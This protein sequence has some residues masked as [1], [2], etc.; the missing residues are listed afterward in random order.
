MRR[1]SFVLA[2]LVAAGCHVDTEGAPCEVPGE[3]T[4][5][6]AGQACGQDLR[7]STRAASCV[8]TMCADGEKQCKDD[9]TATQVCDTSADHVCGEWK[10]VRNC[11]ATGLVCAVTEI[12]CACPSAGGAFHFEPARQPEPGVEPTGA[13][14]PS[15]CRFGSL[16]EALAAAVAQGPGASAIASG[17]GADHPVT[18][19]LELPVGVTLTTDSPDDPTRHALVV[20]SLANT[21]SPAVVLRAGAKLEGFT[22]RNEGASTGR[23]VEVSAC[24]GGP[25]AEIRHV[26][27]LARKSD[28]QAF[29]TGIA[30]VE[31]CG[32]EL[33]DVVV[34]GA[35]APLDLL[36][37]EGLL[38]DAGAGA[39]T[40]SVVDSAFEANETG[41][42]LRS[43]SFAL[44]GSRVEANVRRGMWATQRS[45]GE[46]PPV[47]LNIS[48]TVFTANGDTGLKLQE[49]PAGSTVA[50]TGLEIYG[51]RATTGDSSH[52]GQRRAGGLVLWGSPPVT[53][54]IKGSRIFQNDHDQVGVYSTTPWNLSG[55]AA[56]PADVCSTPNVFAC[57]DTTNTTYRLV[58]FSGPPL[59]GVKEDATYNVWDPDPPS[60]I[61]NVNYGEPQ[62]CTFSVPVPTLA[63]LLPSCASTP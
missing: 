36:V 49:L 16:D 59:G 34:S 32:A 51:N 53:F 38:V 24:Q 8:E 18:A 9:A 1:L 56:P 50:L 29:A 43:G 45:G 58:Y 61:V 44:D 31:G 52:S 27:V 40:T 48:D 42:V 30:V 2:A 46:P 62:S 33:E 37:G 6:P 10:I 5:C 39:P 17:A 28:T 21:G 12:A 41:I 20:T 19:P 4:H 57:R 15:A 55:V 22:L 63:L 60:D 35:S 23:G 25:S 7:C 3:R 54:A 47:S 26:V 11:A 13:E 14:S